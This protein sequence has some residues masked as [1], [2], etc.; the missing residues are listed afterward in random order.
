M[1]EIFHL[2]WPDMDNFHLLSFF[3]FLNTA[4]TLTFQVLDDLHIIL[5]SSTSC[6]VSLWV[7]AL[8]CVDLLLGKG[9]AQYPVSICQIT[10]SVWLP[11]QLGFETEHFTKLQII[12]KPGPL[13]Q[14]IRKQ[15]GGRN[16]KQIIVNIYF[17]F[18][19]RNKGKRR[20]LSETFYTTNSTASYLKMLH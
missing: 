15:R 11:Q 5:T 13:F 2:L 19:L 7:V 3:F 18:K 12:T 17:N 8:F 6:V 4:S 20:P 1:K 16:W 14:N 10:L 9:C